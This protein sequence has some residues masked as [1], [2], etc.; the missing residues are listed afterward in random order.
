MSKWSD[1]DDKTLEHLKQVFWDDWNF[2]TGEQASFDAVGEI[3]EE[4]ERR[5]TLSFVGS[6]ITM[7]AAD[8]PPPKP[9][10]GACYWDTDKK[11]MR[12]FDGTQW[13][14]ITGPIGP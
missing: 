11:M 14:D 9:K 3:E 2:G 13:H 4:I 8:S 7:H 1:H 5:K 10:E 12:V 6:G